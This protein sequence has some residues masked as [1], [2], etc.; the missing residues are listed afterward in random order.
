M[1]LSPAGWTPSN[2][3]SSKGKKSE[4]SGQRPEDFMDDEVR[5]CLIYIYS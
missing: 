1:H 4:F 3:V 5:I 2:F